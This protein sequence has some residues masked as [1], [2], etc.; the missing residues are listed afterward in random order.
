MI[1]SNNHASPTG[2][3]PFLI[4]A[5]SNTS[6]TQTPIPSTNLPKY[7]KQIGHEVPEPTSMRYEAYQSVIDTRIR[8]AWLYSLYLNPQNFAAVAVPL[9]IAPTTSSGIVNW[10]LASQLRAAAETELLKT[11]VKIDADDL[12][13]EAEKAFEALSILLGE[14]EWFMPC[15]GSDEVEPTLFDASVFAYTHLLLD[16]DLA[17]K[18]KKL[19]RCVTKRRN[20]VE[21]RDRLY[22]KYWGDR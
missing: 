7:A 18:D 16:E 12:Y 6:D 19:V 4:P 9:Y 14:N 1:S 13:A 2:I 8:S 10:A 5:Y 17:W 3:L 22:R 15:D 11:S 20:L 21:H